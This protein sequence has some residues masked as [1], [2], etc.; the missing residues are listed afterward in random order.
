VIDDP[1]RRLTFHVADET[2]AARV[3]LK[4]RVVKTLRGRQTDDGTLGLAHGKTVPGRAAGS[5]EFFEA[6]AIKTA[7]SQRPA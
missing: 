6:D 7:I 1:V 4:L 3:V 5:I 2:D